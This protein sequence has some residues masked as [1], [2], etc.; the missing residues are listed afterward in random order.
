MEITMAELTAMPSV[1]IPVTLV[2]AGNRRR[3]ENMI[4]KTIG[5]SWGASAV[6]TTVWTGVRLCDLLKHV[7]VKTREEGAGHVCFLGK[8]QLPKDRYGTSMSI[9]K[10]MHQAS[11]VLIA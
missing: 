2:C 4:K 5:F 3:E 11:D 6:S 1:K 8:D 10:A 7:G 9:V